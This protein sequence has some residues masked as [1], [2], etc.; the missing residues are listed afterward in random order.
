[1]RASVTLF[2][3]A[4]LAVSTAAAGLTQASAS[5]A[6][7]AAASSRSDRAILRPSPTPP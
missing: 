7:D 2:G 1:M 4:I 3:T 5:G 6:T